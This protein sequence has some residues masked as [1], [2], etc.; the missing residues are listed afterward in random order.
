M[1]P[2]SFTSRPT[3]NGKATSLLWIAVFSFVLFAFTAQPALGANPPSATIT[4]SSTP[5][6]FVTTATGGASNGESTCV[7]G[8]NCDTFTLTVGG[9]ASDYAGKVVKFNF[10][11]TLPVTDYDFYIHK[12]TVTGPIVTTGVN[13]GAP[14]TSDRAALD[15][16]SAGVG[17]YVVHIVYFSAAA[18]DQCHGVVSIAAANTA[19]RTAT[20][21]N[22]GIA[23][24]PN[25]PLKCPVTV[26]D[27]EPSNRTD[28]MGNCY[29]TGI[30]GFP[31]GVDLWYF[32]LNPASATY[33]PNMRVPLYRGQ[34]DAFSPSSAADLGGDGGGDVDLAVG[35][36]I[37]SGNTVP[38][39]AFSSLIAAN[40]SSGQSFDLAKTYSRN[41]AGNVTGGAAADD[42]Q[43]EEFL[44][45]TSVYLLYR[46][47]APAVT[48]IQRSNDGGF[49][50]GAA[51]TVGSI[52]QVGPIDVHQ[53]T[54]T[55]FAPGST[56]VM[57]VGQPSTPTGE[58]LS[59]DYKVRT[60]ADDPN[61]VA[62][63]F[64]VTK[65]AD[66][67]TAK[68]TVYACYSN[69][70]DIFLKSSKDQGITW[71]D[72]V[73]VNNPAGPTKVNLFPW[74]ET[75]PTPGS[76]GVVWY[77]TT[78]S[79]NDDTAQ[80]KVYF[81]QSFNADTATPSFSIAEVTEAEHVIHAANI[82]EGGL[83]GTANRNLL[84]YFQVSFDPSGAAVVA[85][86]DDHNDYDG[87]TYVARQISGPSIKGGFLA[88]PA[89]GS[90]LK[91]PLNTPVG[92]DVFP[93]IQ[94]GLNGEQV[95]D[96]E[97][98]VENGLLARAHAADPFDIS[99]VRYDTSGTGA[100]LAIAASI[101]VTDLSTIPPSGTWQ[102][103]FAVNAPHS[104]LGSTGTYTNG[105]SDRGDQFFLQAD[106]DA[107]G[108]PTY[109]Y[110]TV[111]RNSDGSLTYTTVGAADTG[112]FNQADNTISI[113]VSAAKLNA[114]LAAGHTAITNG[115][116]VTGLRATSKTSVSGDGRRDLTRGGTQF[117]VHDSAFPYPAA[118][119][120]PTPLPVASPLPTGTPPTIELANI[121]TRV[122]VKT[123]DSVGIGGFI[124]RTTSP[125]RLLIRGTG[126]S[127]SGFIGS[128]FLADPIL[129]IKNASGTVI[130]SNDDWRSSQQAEISASGLAPVND[131]EAAVIV[132][133]P[134]GN[135]T[136]ILQGKNNGQGIGLV[137]IY[138]IGAESKADLG[139]IATRGLVGAGDEVLIGGFIVRDVSFQN[140]PQRILIRG[141]GPS[142]PTTQLP[143]PL[144]DPFL[145]LHDAQGT[146]ITSNDDWQSS[147]DA[148]AIS[149]TTIAPTNPKESAI[150]R[151]LAPGAYTA[152]MRG[153]SGGTGIGLVEIYNLGNQ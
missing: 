1:I 73:K 17:A 147:P 29:V 118:P 48:Q 143:N 130:A 129:E 58:P 153:V 146:I 14:A 49:S 69:D 66:D 3:T 71:T 68:G 151:T 42:R 125:K 103:A 135:Y 76:V 45:S 80:W 2:N 6:P 116:V 9:A 139:N 13:D 55:V 148:A 87:A 94:P 77:G 149:Q 122:S 8:T 75:G 100:S 115:T 54:G 72:P 43:W 5:I 95:T 152:V 127:L 142:I 44:G 12:G 11:W 131:K 85:Y 88:A 134:G 102:A 78:A 120:A 91:I 70:K 57:G 101:R 98:D 39:L 121:S 67:G 40:I 124:I 50:F 96:F 113:Q 126:P 7:D 36:S 21:T 59:T 28:F 82:S 31:A 112:T 62:H 99:T 27:G 92:T 35:F 90:A 38:T 132:N 34:P 145:E 26:R 140:Q 53:A 128:G 37:A 123:G 89:E 22:T 107:S 56:G 41:P 79:A 110:G 114:A 20:Y 83:T 144:Q 52:G 63:I 106:T 111:V 65:V 18:A 133:L 60:A 64:F 141:I 150:L 86:T 84:D 33:D 93:P 136:A 4:A 47:L 105:A 97:Q 117:V 108:A 137:E 16:A 138:D 30:R 25:V 10:S 15:P 61:G 81:A 74:M 19:L 109:S 32:D 104:S 23:F 24:S 119:P 51:S 46:T